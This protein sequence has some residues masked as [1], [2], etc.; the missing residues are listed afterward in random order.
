MPNADIDH[1]QR[2]AL[3]VHYANIT[4]R[5][6]GRRLDIDPKTVKFIDNPEAVKLFRRQYR[7]PW[8][9]EA[10]EV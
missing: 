7:K 4:H 2:G 6:C 5:L 1:G 3:L 8:V 9:I 10:E